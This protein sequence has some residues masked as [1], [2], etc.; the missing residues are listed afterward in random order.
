MAFESGAGRVWCPT[1]PRLTQYLLTPT[2]CNCKSRWGLEATFQCEY[3][4][5]V[6]NSDT[7]AKMIVLL[8]HPILDI[9][10]AVVVDR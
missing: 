3:N 7:S 6:I 10:D 4:S 2:Q 9:G 8:W 1:A 5:L